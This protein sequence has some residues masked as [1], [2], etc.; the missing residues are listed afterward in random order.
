MICIFGGAFL[1]LFIARRLIFAQ[2][3]VN[4]VL[5]VLMLAVAV[6]TVIAGA[7][8]MSQLGG[9][10]VWPALGLLMGFVAVDMYRNRG[11]DMRS[12]RLEAGLCPHCGY[13]LRKSEERCPECGAPL[14]AEITRWR[15]WQAQITERRSRAAYPQAKAPE[16]DPLDPPERAEP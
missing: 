14:P 6:G 13:D 12:R 7:V 10:Y 1:L 4:P 15:Q 9:R 11:G 8:W 5:A 3:A 2:N 16:P